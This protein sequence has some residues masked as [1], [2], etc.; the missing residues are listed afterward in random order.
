M[1]CALKKTMDNQHNNQIAPEFTF[2]K[3]I[4]LIGMPGTF[5]STVGKLLAKRIGF[6]FCD[7]DKMVEQK[8]DMSIPDTFT[9]LGEDVFRERETIISYDAA[10][11]KRTVI[12]TGGGIVTRPENIEALKQT[13]IIVQLCAHVYTI[14]ARIRN[15][16]AR[17]LLQ[18]LTIEKLSGMYQARGHLYTAAADFKVITDGK[19]PKHIA[20]YII[21]KLS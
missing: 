8:F 2:S 18:D 17:P 9:Q 12:A 14:F 15:S 21:K 16:K 19:M 1:N 4:A 10:Q 3:N 13:S 7:T 6:D 5:K 11:K 20:D